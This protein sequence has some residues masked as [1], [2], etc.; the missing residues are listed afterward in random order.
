M[1]PNS[2]L[3]RVAVRTRPSLALIKYWGKADTHEN[4]PATSSLAVNLEGLFTD[5]HVCLSPLDDRMEINGAA[6]RMERFTPFFNKARQL[7]HTESHFHASSR[8]NFPTSAGLA[9]SSS[10]F[11]ALAYGCAHLAKKDASL[12]LVSDLARFG[13][14][15]AARPLFGGFTALK[16]GAAYAEPVHPASHWPELR[17]IIA[18]VK[19]EPKKIS[20]RQAMESART[21]SPYYPAWIEKAEEMFLEGLKALKNKNLDALGPLI[22]QS[23]LMMFGTMLTSRAPVIY[24]EPQTVALIKM[25]ERL[26]EAGYSAWETMDAGPQVKILTLEPHS[27]ALICRLK[28]AFPHLQFL[29]SKPGGGPEI[30][31]NDPI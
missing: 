31:Q 27:H 23:Y 2:S 5:T 3:P 4:V 10:G 21:T 28:T 13:S 7:L 22:Q 20:S 19:S 11:S 25:C 30:L 6:V 18:V 9:S 24:W 14:A 26:R 1:I 15:S 8:S 17:V 12:E 16:R 29:L